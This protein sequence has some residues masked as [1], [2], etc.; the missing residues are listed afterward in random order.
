MFNTGFKKK[1][2]LKQRI[3]ESERILSK[4]PDRIPIICEKALG[5]YDLPD[6][7]KTKYLVPYDL[8][9][10]QF[11]Y[12]IRKRLKLEPEEAMFLFVNNK[13][14]SI[15][16]TIMNVYYYEK[17]PDGFLYIKYSKENMFG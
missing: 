14:M 7:D 5:Q 15:N 11:I 6:I 16:S 3:Y 4:Y 17:D 10:G 12:V 13:M 8:T 9:L 1:Y 2:S